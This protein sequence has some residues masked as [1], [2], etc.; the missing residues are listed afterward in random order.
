M[1]MIGS[2]MLCPGHTY[3]DT[4]GLMRNGFIIRILVPG[5]EGCEISCPA[6][7]PARAMTH[8]GTNRMIKPVWRVVDMNAQSGCGVK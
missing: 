5:L 1:A 2:E 4:I 8:S 6:E 3:H 7:F